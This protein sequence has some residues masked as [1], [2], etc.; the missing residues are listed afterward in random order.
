MTS[1]TQFF[2]ILFLWECEIVVIFSI[3]LNLFGLYFYLLY[4]CKRKQQTITP[5]CFCTSESWIQKRKGHNYDTAET[6]C[7][8]FG[9]SRWSG[10]G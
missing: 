1:E 2:L 8:D 5:P 10:A 6:S 7:R 3:I 4:L 9:T